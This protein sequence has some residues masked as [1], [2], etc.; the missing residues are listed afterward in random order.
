LNSTKINTEEEQIDEND[1]EGEAI[2]LDE[3]L[4]SGALEEDDPGRLATLICIYLY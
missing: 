1:D 2:D 3:Y 4:S